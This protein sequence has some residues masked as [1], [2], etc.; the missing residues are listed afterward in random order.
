MERS[1]ITSRMGMEVGQRRTILLRPVTAPLL[2]N[3]VTEYIARWMLSALVTERRGSALFARRCTLQAG[4]C[5]QRIGT[6]AGT[7]PNLVD[8]FVAVALVVAVML[9]KIYLK[10]NKL[11]QSL[12]WL[13]YLDIDVQLTYSFPCRSVER[14]SYVMARFEEEVAHDMACIRRE[15]THEPNP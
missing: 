8:F 15:A 4:K 2:T 11:G 13:F 7:Q 9:D 14:P 12:K 5:A 1:G 3:T 10:M 6:C